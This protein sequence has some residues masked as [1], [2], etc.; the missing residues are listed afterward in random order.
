MDLSSPQFLYPVGALWAAAA[1]EGAAAVDLAWLTDPPGQAG[2]VGRRGPGA[3]VARRRR[4]AV[5][6]AVQD[7]LPAPPR[8][9][10]VRAL[11]MSQSCVDAACAGQALWPAASGGLKHG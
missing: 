5:E 7:G 10:L 6:P 1:G 2:P 4:G 11:F 8:L 9:A 3:A